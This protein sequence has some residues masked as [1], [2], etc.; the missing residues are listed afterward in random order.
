MHFLEFFRDFDHRIRVCGGEKV[1]A[2]PLKE[3]QF[4]KVY[5]TLREIASKEIVADLQLFELVE[6]A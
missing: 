4:F 6:L 1:V 2:V 3:F 5:K